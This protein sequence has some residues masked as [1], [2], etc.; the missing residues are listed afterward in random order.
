MTRLTVL[1]TYYNLAAYLDAAIASIRAQTL[2]DFELVLLD[3]GSKD[4][5]PAIAERHAAQDPRI[6]IARSATNLGIPGNLNR[7]LAAVT[8]ELVA[9]MDGDDVA[10]PER[11]ARQ[12]AYLDAHP[13]V[14][15]VGCIP[16]MVDADLQPIG[17]LDDLY[18]EKHEDI[19]REL[20][21]GHGWAFLQPTA[22]MRTAAV[23]ATGSFRTDLATSMDLDFFLR[24]GETGRLA[25]VPEILHHYRLRVGSVTH[26]QDQG[27]AARH[28]TALA[29][30]YRRRGLTKPMPTAVPDH[31]E[32]TP[33]D[34]HLRWAWWALSSGN[35]RTARRQAWFAVRR[36][37][38]A[39]RCWKALA[40]AWRGRK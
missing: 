6:R 20:L 30:A 23:R 21:E 29:E 31:A 28:N 8:T 39:W 18:H 5:S 40:C 32:T 11:L 17:T 22:T 38:W 16:L 7:G 19:E 24:L 15:G 34:L 25:N 26:A 13:E 33:T 12:V 1:L 14:V 35:V 2:R 9:L 3:D 27:R 37:P 36:A 10:R 4:G